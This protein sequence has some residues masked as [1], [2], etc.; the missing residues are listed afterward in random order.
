MRC[1]YSALPNHITMATTTLYYGPEAN[2][3]AQ[4]KDSTVYI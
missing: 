3:F 2:I 1:I 4:D